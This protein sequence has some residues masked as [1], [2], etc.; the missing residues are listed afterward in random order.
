MFSE[1]TSKKSQKALDKID[2]REKKYE[3]MT[4]EEFEQEVAGVNKVYN[5]STHAKKID[6]YEQA[7]AALRMLESISGED[8]TKLL[9]ALKIKDADFESKKNDDGKTVSTSDAEKTKMIA[10]KLMGILSQKK[11]ESM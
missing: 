2:K 1:N 9:K 10:D 5:D 8:R 6:A 4:E 11:I 7:E 3:N